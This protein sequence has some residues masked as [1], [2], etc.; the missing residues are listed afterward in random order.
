MM[1]QR[2]RTVVLWLLMVVFLLRVY[3]QAQVAI[4]EPAYLPPMGDWYSGL[5]PYPLLLFIQILILML[6]TVINYDHT[7]Q[8]GPFI[9]LC[10]RWRR[11]VRCFAAIYLTAMVVRFVLHLNFYSGWTGTLPIFMHWML[12]AY[13]FVLTMNGGDVRRR[14]SEGDHN[15]GISKA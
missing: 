4:Y 15:D 1:N 13:L 5:V 7:R 10:H 6:M 2:H 8:N 12:A 3:G 9:D 11:P 14:W